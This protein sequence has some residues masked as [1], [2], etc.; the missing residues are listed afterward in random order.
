MCPPP[1]KWE[2]RTGSSIPVLPA[3]QIKVLWDN[4]RSWVPIQW[5]RTERFSTIEKVFIQ[6]AP[7]KKMR[8]SQI[9]TKYYPSIGIPPLMETPR[10]HSESLSHSIIMNHHYNPYKSSPS[11]RCHRLDKQVSEVSHRNILDGV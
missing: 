4:R 8:K 6:S 1:K 3:A 2:P 11:P 9:N 5:G 10:C 7:N